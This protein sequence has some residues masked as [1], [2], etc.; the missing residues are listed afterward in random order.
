MSDRNL[1]VKENFVNFVREKKLPNSASPLTPETAGLSHFDV[2]DIFESQVM[3]RHLD[4]QSRIMQKK[5]QSFYTIGSA[6]HEGNAAYAKAF[7]VTDM[8]FLHYRSGAFVIQRS[9]QVP[10]QTPLYDMLLSFAASKDDPISGGRHKVLG[11]KALS[12]PPQTSTIASHVPKAV[13]TAFSVLLAE[14]IGIKGKLP[15]DSLVVCNFGDASS[16]HSTIQGAINATCW[17]AYQSV[18]VPI[19]FICEDNGIGISTSTPKGW[20]AAN[21]SQRPGLTYLFCD[22]LNILETYKTAKQAEKIAREQHK[23]VFL[24]IRTVRL[25]GH[26]GSDA[27]FVYRDVKDIE[28]TEFQ[29]PLLHSARILLENN[30][31]DGEQIIKIYQ[32][33]AQRIAQIAEQVAAKPKLES[34]EQVQ[35]SIIPPTVAKSLIA[36]QTQSVSAEQRSQLFSHEKHNINKPQHMAK[37]LNWSLIDLMAQH[38]HIVMCGEDIA[39]KGGVYNVTTKLSDK[40]GKNRVINTL[41]DEQSI[42]G[43][44]IG[45]AHNG[46]LPIPE[47]QFLAYV[48]NAEDQIRGEAATLPFFSDGQYTNPMVIRIAGLAYQKGFGGHFHNDNSFAVFRD[49]P[50]LILACPSNGADA[51]EMMRSCVKLAHEQQ[52]LV[53]FLEPIA[54]YMT[55]DLHQQGD[56]LWT[57]EYL[58]PAQAPAE[59][60][61]KISVFGEGKDICIL[62]YGNGY[63][64][65]RQAEQILAAQGIHCSVVDLRWLAPLDEQGI[66]EQVNACDRVIIVDECR[67]T[68]SISEALVTLIH[69]S[70]APLMQD[71]QP[72]PFACRRVTA[73]DSFIP[74]GSAAYHV[75]PSTAD[76]VAMAQQLMTSI[77]RPEDIITA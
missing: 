53:V 47:I 54:L 46:F 75:L 39:K 6:G 43:L 71:K 25:L 2:I 26:A 1:L 19:V 59:I 8:A 15:K 10:G 42:L 64:L 30:I 62:S 76:I 12:I 60:N 27:E 40:F 29:D 52:R 48:H 20:V 18:P 31:L 4:L 34:A 49:I 44:A 38:D 68:G 3:S 72:A 33:L 5:G 69:E 61:Q 35:A 56:A 57:S 11:S 74:L 41:L 7:R 37:L 55:K 24:H 17:A 21:F 28:A 32:D 65:S 50:G 66:L 9:K 51:V 23:P 70:R 22:G 63:F 16:N 36:Q 13:G 58:P 14:R 45:M 77:T 67:E 73:K